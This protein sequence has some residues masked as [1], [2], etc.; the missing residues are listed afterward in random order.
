MPSIWTVAVYCI[1]NMIY[2]PWKI[3]SLYRI[4]ATL[5]SDSELIILGE[6][7]PLLFMVHFNNPQ[8]ILLS[9]WTLIKLHFFTFP[10]H[11]AWL[12]HC[13][14]LFHVT[15]G[16]NLIL[17][18]GTQ[19]DLPPVPP[20]FPTCGD[21]LYVE[22]KFA[23]EYRYKLFFSL[24]LLSRLIDPKWCLPCCRHKPCERLMNVI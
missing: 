19:A 8:H 7:L 2:R 5:C 3:Q 13:H 11:R 17:H 6:C 24:S 4:M 1:V 21:H 20:N 16:M 10:Q 23:F 9:Q 15:I 14:F 22:L 18:V 12:F